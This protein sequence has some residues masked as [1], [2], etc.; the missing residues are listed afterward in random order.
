MKGI[1]IIAILAISYFVAN[2]LFFKILVL[3]FPD[4][5]T[6]SF[7]VLSFVVPPIIAIIIGAL[8]LKL[9]KK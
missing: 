2:Y 6:E 9:F 7:S 1:V 8:C 5:P 4:K 3:L